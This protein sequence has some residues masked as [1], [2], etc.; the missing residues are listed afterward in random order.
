KIFVDNDDRYSQFLCPSLMDANGIRSY[1]NTCPFIAPA[2]PTSPAPPPPPNPNPPPPN[3][4]PPNPPPPNPPPP[5]PP[6]SCTATI[7]PGQVWGDRYNTSVTVSG[8]TNW[9]VVVA[10]TAPQRMSATWNGTPSWDSTGYVMTMRSNGSGNTFGFTT[11][12]NG[13]STARPQIRSCTPA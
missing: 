8:A 7:T 2:P 1:R 11:M 4:P 5:P 3:P 9:S 13:N 12:F 6:A 10:L